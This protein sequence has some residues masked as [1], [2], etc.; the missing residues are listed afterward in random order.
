MRARSPILVIGVVGQ[1]FGLSL[2][3][4]SWHAYHPLFLFS[5]AISHRFTSPQS[6]PIFSV[7][8]QAISCGEDWTD[9]RVETH[10]SLQ[11]HTQVVRSQYTTSHELELQY[12]GRAWRLSPNHVS[13]HK[14]AMRLLKQLIS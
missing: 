2:Y 7:L 12:F 4:A 5:F 3:S 11:R 9:F 13:S 14:V 6:C 8:M 1:Y 10:V